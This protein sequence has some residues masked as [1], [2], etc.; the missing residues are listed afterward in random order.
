MIE[1]NTPALERGLSGPTRNET[2]ALGG[3]AILF[4]IGWMAIITYVLHAS[5]PF[6]PIHLPYAE[7]VQ[8]RFWIPEGW[9]FFTRNPREERVTPY[10]LSGNRWISASLGPHGRSSNLFGLDRISRAQ[11]VELGLLLQRLPGR[12]WRDCTA[13]PIA[14]LDSVS[15]VPRIRNRSPRPTLC[16]DIAFV[17]QQ[18]IPWAWVRLPGAVMPSRV[19]RIRSTC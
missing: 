9:G 11:N 14:C 17:R 2:R 5:L 1:T 3:A 19:T 7:R 6:N 13:S 8:A 10:A 4:A 12:L 18:P 15:V 16:G